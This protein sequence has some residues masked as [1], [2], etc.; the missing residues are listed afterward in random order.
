M[1]RPENP[2]TVCGAETQLAEIEPHPVKATLEIHGYLCD[3]CGPVK[4]V[5]VLR[6]TL[7]HQ[8]PYR[9]D[10]RPVRACFDS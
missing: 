8:S 6:R 9:P 7:G 1:L 5:V 3:R 4:S 10:R 2:C